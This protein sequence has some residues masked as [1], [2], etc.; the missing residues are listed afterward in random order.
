MH[1][2]LPCPPAVGQRLAL[3]GCRTHHA[4]IPA[5]FPRLAGTD[6]RYGNYASGMRQYRFITRHRKGKW[7]ASL[8]EA[9]THANA[10]GAGF[11]DAA[12][13]FVS[14]RGTVLE[15]RDAASQIATGTAIIPANSPAN[16]RKSKPEQEPE[17][18]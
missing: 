17:P 16:A 8:A 5:Y 10:I 3:G 13:R 6:T 9:Q 11:L 15:L 1:S 7:Y 4:N 12:G 18:A 2:I 14:Y